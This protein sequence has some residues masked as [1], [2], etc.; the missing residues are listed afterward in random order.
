MKQQEGS[1]FWLNWIR[2]ELASGRHVELSAAGWSMFP[3]IWR[4]SQFTVSYVAF[5]E[6]EIG[7]LIAFENGQ[8]AI[9]HRIVQIEEN[10][11]SRRVQTQGD[12]NIEPDEWIT[13]VQYLG[14]VLSINGQ[15]AHKALLPNFQVK[16]RRNELLKRGLLF[17]ATPYRAGKRLL[18]TLQ[19]Q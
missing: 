18:K 12:S 10:A 15:S 4:G 5:E 16:H 13:I 7:N 6:L 1:S 17:L 9:L 14:K 8:K 2:Q 11:T 19:I 3:S